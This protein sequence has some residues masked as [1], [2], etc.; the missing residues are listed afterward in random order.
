MQKALILLSA[1]GS[2]GKYLGEGHIFFFWIENVRSG[3]LYV[4]Q[5]GFDWSGCFG[6][7]SVI[8]LCVKQGDRYL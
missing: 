2:G 6:K 4:K 5:R 3:F 8:K 1:G 7:I